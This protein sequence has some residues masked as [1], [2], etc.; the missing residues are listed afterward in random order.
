ML[1]RTARRAR[2]IQSGSANLYLIYI[3]AALLALL[4]L[5]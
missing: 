1:H 5:A 2:L 4:V 3:L